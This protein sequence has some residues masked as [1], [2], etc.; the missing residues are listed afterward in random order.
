MMAVTPA[1]AATG[2]ESAKGKKASEP[3]TEPAA[4]RAGLPHGD[5]DRIDAAHLPGADAQQH[6]LLGQHDGV[7]LHVPHDAPGEA[8]I[9]QFSVCRL[10]AR[11]HLP[12]AF[13]I[14]RQ[15]A[16]LHEKAA[17]DVPVLPGRWL[18]VQGADFHQP[19][20][21][22]P[23]RP[24]GENLEGRRLERRGDDRF[25]KPLRLGEHFGCRRVERSIDA[26]HRAE[27]AEW[28]AVQAA[29]HRDGQAVRHR[30]AAR[31]VVLDHHGRGAWQRADDRQGAVQIQQIVVRQ[32]L[33]MQLPG[34]DKIR[35]G[36]GQRIE[37]SA[38]VRILAVAQF[39]FSPQHER[40][41]RGKVGAP[42]RL[43]EILGDRLIVFGCAGIRRSRQT[44]P[45]FQRRAAVGRDFIEN[46]RVLLGRRRDRHE[47]MVLRRRPNQ[48]RPA[49]V[50]LLDRFVVRNT[51]PGDGRLERIEIHHHQIERHDAMFG[52]LPHVLGIVAAAEDAA[53][54]S[55]VQRFHAA[56]HHFGPAG[57]GT[58]FFDR[59]ARLLQMPPR[60]AGAVKLHA[61]SR[62]PARK[63]SQPQLIANTENRA[64][65]GH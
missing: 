65:Y 30:G 29:P 25:D 49:N 16:V 3:S 1:E 40:Q 63:I 34:R 12:L 46:C 6:S 31:I 13:R 17:G 57:I 54:N 23:L 47:A 10:A 19:D 41:R 20:V 43:H 18:L 52:G 2:I 55:W 53:V 5:F 50:D 58:H 61:R 59:Q 48:A 44:P 45:Q 51:R 33:A 4:P 14:G 11:D 32:L 38:L 62:Q 8:Q 7:R 26:D 21:G 27:R 35:A 42:G 22:L 64:F 9:G 24:S 37:R 36:R 56:V 60:A 28:I 15:V 39:H